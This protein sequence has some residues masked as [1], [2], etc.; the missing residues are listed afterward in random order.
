M[1]QLTEY[2]VRLLDILS[3]QPAELAETIAA[4][5]SGE[6]SVRRTRDGSTV[7]QIAAHVRDLEVRAFLPR[8]RRILTETD[9]VLEMFPSHRWAADDYAPDELMTE[10]LADF[11]RAREEAL[12]LMRPLAPADWSRA[13]FHP[14]SGRRTALW[15]AE[16]MYSHAQGH[17]DEIRRARAPRGGA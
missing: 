9:P 10:I 2:R 13:G 6:W 7:H 1:K 15:W 8:F 11:A 5:P 17:L 14:P 16:R 12:I 4:I 3:R